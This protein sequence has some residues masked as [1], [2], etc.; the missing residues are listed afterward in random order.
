[1]VDIE[2]NIL[3]DW[4]EK[5]DQNSDI[6]NRLST[7]EK[8]STDFVQ[9]IESLSRQQAIKEVISD[10]ENEEKNNIVS[11]DTINIEPTPLQN[12]LSQKKDKQPTTHQL[13]SSYIIAQNPD[14]SLEANI[15]REESYMKVQ[16]QIITLPFG[17]DKFFADA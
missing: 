11:I 14:S 3:S 5:L 12:Q 7:F 13:L 2:K 15:W 6:N 1:M 16:S 17:L 4:D 9:Y 10:V 8:S